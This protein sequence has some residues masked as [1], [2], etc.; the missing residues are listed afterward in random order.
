MLGSI[1]AIVIVLVFMWLLA[2]KWL[3]INATAVQTMD[4]ANKV[5]DRIGEL[6]TATDNLCSSGVITK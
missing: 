3:T 1:F 4:M 2:D 6:L 5:L